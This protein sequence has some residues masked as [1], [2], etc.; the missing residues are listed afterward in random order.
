MIKL[1]IIYN[2]IDDETLQI[3]DLDDDELYEIKGSTLY[4]NEIRENIEDSVSS[5]LLVEFDDETM[6]I[7]V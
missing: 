5:E 7:V 2:V 3:E 1:G 6:E 4:I